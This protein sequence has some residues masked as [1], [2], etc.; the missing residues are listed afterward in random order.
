MAEEFDIGTWCKEVGI[1]ENGAK[2][3]LTAEVRDDLAIT[4]LETEEIAAVKLAPGDLAKFRYGQR[5]LQKKLEQVPELDGDTGS[6]PTSLKPNPA[7]LYTLEQV[8]AFRQCQFQSRQHYRAGPWP[9]RP[10]GSV[11]L[12]GHR[13]KHSL[14]TA[15]TV[16]SSAVICSRTC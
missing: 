14:R 7:G 16:P 12:P 1:S 6:A 13:G 4:L 8:S 5:L 15:Q 3:L 2:K 11:Q 9:H 10:A